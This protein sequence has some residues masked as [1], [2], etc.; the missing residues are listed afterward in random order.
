MLCGC[1]GL[2]WRGSKDI[3]QVLG[4]LLIVSRWR[5]RKD[6]HQVVLDLVWVVSLLLRLGCV[7]QLKELICWD[8]LS[9]WG[10][11]SNVNLGFFLFLCS[12]IVYSSNTCEIRFANEIHDVHR[13][14]F[15]GIGVKR[16][17][18]LIKLF[19]KCAVKVSLLIVFDRVVVTIHSTTRLFSN[20]GKFLLSVRIRTFASRLHNQFKCLNQ[21]F[22][23]IVKIWQLDWEIEWVD[24]LVS[25]RLNSICQVDKVLVHN[26]SLLRVILV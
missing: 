13:S 12:S 1:E 18:F 24:Q 16:M 10:L 7:V 22:L 23:W 6:V 14:V 2:A 25:F 11:C 15:L 20:F 26:E 17:F 3:I 21:V 9:V 4:V 5:G 8:S 19:K